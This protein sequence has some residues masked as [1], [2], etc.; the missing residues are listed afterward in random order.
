MLALTHVIADVAVAALRTEADLTP[1]PGLVDGR[2]S[3]A[4]VDMTRQTLHDSAEALREAFAECA[5]AAVQFEMGSQLRMRIGVIGREGE[6]RMLAATG[7]VNTHRGALWALGLLSAGAAR[8]GV[9]AE[10]IG[11]AAAL[12]AIPDPAS[13]ER[14]SHGQDARRR[15]G[16]RGA[17]GEAQG[18]FPHVTAYAL[19][20]LRRARRDGADEPTARL[21]AL[22]SLIARLDD[23]CLLHRGGRRGLRAV[24]SRAAKV[25]RAGGS[26]T[27]EGQAHF[28]ALDRLCAEQRLSP[29]G[30]A[31]L[32]SATL[33][34]DALD[35]RSSA[36]C[37][38]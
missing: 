21:D 10:A 27:S 29:G 17:A 15:Y 36:T 30:S 32:L 31:D 5:A 33:F 18:G 38:P 20:T 26:G 1:K 9:T 16:A 2:G 7:G 34:L 8:S 11:F 4:H 37:K 13:R 12:A 35:E 6:R 14:L 24:Q 3:G 25:L 23:T 28:A 19:P 22:L